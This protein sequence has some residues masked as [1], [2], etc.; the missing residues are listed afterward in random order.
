MKVGPSCC[1]RIAAI[2]ADISALMNLHFEAQLRRVALVSKAGSLAFY[3]NLGELFCYSQILWAGN[4]WSSSTVREDWQTWR[5]AERL[6]ALRSEAGPTRTAGRSCTLVS[7]P[8]SLSSS[9][10]TDENPTHIEIDDS[11]VCRII[12]SCGCFVPSRVGEHGGSG[13]EKSSE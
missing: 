12:V 8:S 7:T 1:C 4:T 11:T 3:Q 10:H 5:E 13:R 2:S 9:L 6:A